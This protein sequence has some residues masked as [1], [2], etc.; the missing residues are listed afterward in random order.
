MTSS[1]SPLPATHNQPEYTVSELAGAIKQT[2]ET[3]FGR[4]RVRAE[5][6]GVKRA[7]SGH[8]YMDLKDDRAV[9]NGVCWKGVA[10]KLAVAPENG[11]EVICTGRMSSYP[12]R[13]NYQII[14][15]QMEPAGI[16]ALMALLEKRKAQLMREGLFAPQRK[17]PLPFLPRTIGVITSP[18]GA[19]IRDILH[20]LQDRFPT[21]V[22]VWPVAV[23]GKGADVSISAAIEGFNRFDGIYT[24]PRPDVLI[25]ARG[26][27]SMEDLWCF[28][29]ENVV[30]AAAASQIPLISAVGHETDTTLIDYASSR[31]A[32]TPTAAA[33][34]AVPVLADMLYTLKE[35]EQRLNHTILRLLEHQHQHVT[36][37]ARGLTSPEIT[38]D[39]QTQ[40][41]D[42]WAERLENAVQRIMNLH[43]IKLSHIQDAL[44]PTQL[45][46]TLHMH[47]QRLSHISAPLQQR[48]L[49]AIRYQHQRL[50]Q[51]NT[52]LTGD[53]LLRHIN[54]H[55]SQLEEKH[56]RLMQQCQH[57][58]HHLTTSLQ[59]LSRMLDALSHKRI[60]Q[61]GFAYVTNPNNT[62]IDSVHTVKDT[63]VTVHFHDGHLNMT[64]TDSLPCDA[65]APVKPSS[66]RKNTT[67]P[68]PGLFDGL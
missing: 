43:H 57:R 35:Y 26:G 53:P 44:S 11:M 56:S 23:Q 40:R 10:L 30:R 28:N 63:P 45:Q 36:Q 66:K 17:Q 9:I 18:T 6:S 15:E 58:I 64:R 19:V 67:A 51:V 38:L 25:V 8:Y 50:E 52:R 16:G 27:G 62:L 12:G 7:A 39:M 32:P 29:E 24:P 4:V 34:M 46:R 42:E 65:L 37:L 14:I 20:R 48:I 3:G 21:H 13:S 1:D 47:S 5:L 33:E 49:L 22:L 55:Q 60:L 2:I 68:Q 59:G 41:S 61:R 54:A 31:R